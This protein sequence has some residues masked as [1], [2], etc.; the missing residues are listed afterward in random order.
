MSLV[1][2]FPSRIYRVIHTCCFTLSCAKY[3]TT[4][5][6]LDFKLSQKMRGRSLRPINDN[7]AWTLADIDKSASINL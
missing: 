1:L 5:A 2:F 6:F 4:V 7:I 3:A